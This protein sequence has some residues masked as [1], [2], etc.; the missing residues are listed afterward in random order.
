MLVFNRGFVFD[1]PVAVEVFRFLRPV[2]RAGGG[3]EGAAEG[4]TTV[5]RFVLGRKTFRDGNHFFARGKYKRSTTCEASSEHGELKVSFKFFRCD[6]T[7]TSDVGSG[8]E[9]T[10][11]VFGDNLEHRFVPNCCKKVKKPLGVNSDKV[12][13]FCGKD[14]ILVVF[15]LFAF[16]GEKL[17]PLEV[18]LFW[19]AVDCGR[20]YH[21]E[22]FFG[23]F[24]RSYRTA[25]NRADQVLRKGHGR[26]FGHAWRSDEGDVEIGVESEMAQVEPEATS[27]HC[28]KCGEH[29]PDVPFERGFRAF[30]YMEIVGDEV[31]RGGHEVFSRNLESYGRKELVQNRNKGR[32]ERDSVGGE[33]E[34]ADAD[35]FADGR[36]LGVE[37]SFFVSESGT[38]VK[39]S[40][41]S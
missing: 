22:S 3:L 20:H 27:G 14:S 24:G 35:H 6:T 26:G 7:K 21:G 9:I 16:V 36:I 8:N 37:D 19:L 5:Q 41:F 40:A 10:T 12:D 31:S 17:S 34:V 4:N 33:F 15:E 13:K 30:A 28:G 23:Y 38:D 1:I 11:F 25:A 32:V 18:S 29:S 39:G 2:E